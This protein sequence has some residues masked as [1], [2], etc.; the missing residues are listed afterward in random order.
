MHRIHRP[1]LLNCHGSMLVSHSRATN[2][3][4]KWFCLISLGLP[5]CV[6]FITRQR[7]SGVW[8]ATGATDHFLDALPPFDEAYEAQDRPI[9]WH[10]LLLR[11]SFTY[12]RL[13][14]L[15]QSCSCFT[16]NRTIQMPRKNVWRS[17]PLHHRW[18][19]TR[20]SDHLPLIYLH[21]HTP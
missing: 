14:C 8:S 17:C 15:N 9:C 7:I 19:Q 21:R 5:I 13:C 4:F 12:F 1:H 10:I 16:S 2:V 3:G 11:L 20:P 18:I 6:N